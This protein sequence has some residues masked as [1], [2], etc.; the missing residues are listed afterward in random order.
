MNGRIG[1]PIRLF[2]YAPGR[3]GK[4]AEN[5]FAGILLGAELIF[6]GYAWCNGIAH[7]Q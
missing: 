6:D 3:C 1:L 4:Y 2:T 7:D 5:L